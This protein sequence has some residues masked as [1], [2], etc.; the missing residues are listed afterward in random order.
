MADQANAH[1]RLTLRVHLPPALARQLGARRKQTGQTISAIVVQ[2]LERLLGDEDQ[3][4]FQTSTVNALMEGASTGDMTMRELKTHGDFGLGTFDGLDGEMIELD[5]KI[6]QVRAD[7]HAHPVADS[8]RT[9]FA[10]VSFFKAD[11]SARLDRPCDQAA[12]LAAVAAMLPSQNIFHALRIEGRFDYVKTRA[13]AEQDKSVGLEDAARDEPI[14]EFHEV[15][16]TIVGFFTPDY[17]RGVNVPG[18]VPVV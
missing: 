2:A 11:E 7:G 12:M 1:Q 10:T 16:G 17:L 13:V 6:F 3:T 15:E 18:R 4:T 5:G 9:P 8:A 14:F